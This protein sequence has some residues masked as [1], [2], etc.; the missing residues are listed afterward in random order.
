M[1]GFDGLPICLCYFGKRDSTVVHNRYGV[2]ASFGKFS[3]FSIEIEADSIAQL[4]TDDEKIVYNEWL[5]FEHSP[6]SYRNVKRY[7][8]CRMFY[9]YNKYPIKFKLLE[10]ETKIDERVLA[11]SENLQVQKWDFEKTPASLRLEFEGQD[12]PEIYALALD[13]KSGVAVDNIPLRGS[14]GTVFTNSNTAMLSAIYQNLNA[15]LLILQFG[16]NAAPGMKENY[17]FY[18]RSFYN[19]LSKLKRII[20]G[21]SIIVVGLADMS[22]KDKD[23]YVSLPNVTL[24]RDALK[25][26]AFKADCAFWDTFEAMGGENSMPSWVFAD[27][28]LAEKDFTHFTVKG[29]Q[30]I[31][32]MFYKALMLEYND[33]FNSKIKN[34]KSAGGN[35][36]L[37]SK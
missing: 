19:Q 18:Q 7:L 28:P 27:P 25:N 21:V 12:S 17:D 24:I 2:L 3:P 9:G 14:T 36:Q 8:Q 26:A 37:S 31:A 13:G 5:M 16:G 11:P 33:Y 29:S 22:Q 32:Q 20:P 1:F 23:Q 10:G 4:D 34:D 30:I 6:Y 15:K 35:V